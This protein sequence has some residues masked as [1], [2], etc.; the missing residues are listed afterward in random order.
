MCAVMPLSIHPPRNTG[1]RPASR[2]FSVKEAAKLTSVPSTSVN[3]WSGRAKILTPDV[4][5][6]GRG[7]RKLFSE[8]NLVQIRVTHLLTQRWI[9]LRTI[10]ALMRRKLD[11][12]NPR[13]LV[14]GPVQILVCRGNVDWHLRSSGVSDQGQP[15]GLLEELWH[16]LA[17]H[18]DVLVVNLAKVKRFI[19]NRL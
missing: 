6:A 17:A 12:F 10:R 15:S 11:W 13:T 1:V 8:R 14:W 4:A 9:P 19:L 16:D 2:G 18:E 5:N 3:F 7:S